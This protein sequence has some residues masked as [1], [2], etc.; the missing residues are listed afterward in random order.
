MPN[1]WVD[2]DLVLPTLPHLAAEIVEATAAWPVRPRVVIDPADKEAAFRTAR[3]ALAASGTVTLELA[4]AGVP[5]VAAYR[6]PAWEGAVFRLLAR[7]YIDTVILANLV[8]GENAMSQLLQSDCTPDR[9][10]AGLVPLIAD[11]PARRRQTEAFARIDAVM[12]VDSG[13]PSLRAAAAIL[14][15]AAKGRAYP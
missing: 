7:R 6:V 12:Q 13:A 4:F 9:L 10:A 11:T 15:I 3:A 2:F 8:L 14:E 1:R 5:T